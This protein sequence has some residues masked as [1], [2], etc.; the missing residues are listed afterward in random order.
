[1]AVVRATATLTLLF[2]SLMRR[3]LVSGS[4]IICCVAWPT[5]CNCHRPMAVISTANISTAANPNP[6]RAPMFSLVNFI[7]FIH[8]REV[9]V[10]GK[11]AIPALEWGASRANRRK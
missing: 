2:Q 1:M 5:E 11:A 7:E 8:S 9:F 10:A 4:C 3:S 6:K